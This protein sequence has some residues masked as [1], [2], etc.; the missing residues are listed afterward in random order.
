MNILKLFWA[1]I[2]IKL[3]GYSKEDIL[4]LF[5]ERKVHLHEGMDFVSAHYKEL[6]HLDFL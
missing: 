6:N 5:R 4:R 2:R 1:G 3:K